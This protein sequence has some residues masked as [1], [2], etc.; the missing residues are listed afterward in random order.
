MNIILCGFKKSG[1][2]T[3]GKS[4]AEKLGVNFFDT[5]QVIERNYLIKHHL[6][7]SF[8]EIYQREGE[9][10]FRKLELE[11]IK[12]LAPVRKSIISLGGGALCNPDTVYFLKKMGRIVYLKV[13]RET[14]LKRILQDTPP[15]FLDKQNIESSFERLY[16]ERKPVYEKNA[17]IIVDTKGL[18]LEDTVNSIIQHL[19]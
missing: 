3:V 7:L 9:K 2:T 13:P 18:S 11:A 1:K 12:S 4:L 16:E 10:G 14:L 15:A 19:E 17:D 6:E 5:D 8:R